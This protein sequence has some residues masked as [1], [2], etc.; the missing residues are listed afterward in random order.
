[1]GGRAGVS[2]SGV[3][4]GV[5]GQEFSKRLNV[6]DVSADVGESA[7]RVVVVAAAEGGD[8]GCRC[9]CCRVSK[10]KKRGDGKEGV[11]IIEGAGRDLEL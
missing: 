7:S 8:G 5:G 11:Y 3:L 4:S 1:M 10:E 6:S 2:G 9:R